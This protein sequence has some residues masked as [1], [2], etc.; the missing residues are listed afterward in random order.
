MS[1]LSS[2]TDRLNKATPGPWFWS[3]NVDYHSIQLSA[4]VEGWGTCSLIQF[5]RSG[6]QGAEPVFMDDKVMMHRARDLAVYA[7]AKDAITRDDPRVYRG[8][9]VGFRNPNADLIAHAPTDIAYLLGRVKA[10]LAL[11]HKVSDD[12]G[13]L[14]NECGDPDWPCATVLA[15]GGETE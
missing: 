1:D 12:H 10:G 2:I 8:D 14:C 9:I 15:L 3:G 13:D 11:H 7:V 5:R 4:R 6:M